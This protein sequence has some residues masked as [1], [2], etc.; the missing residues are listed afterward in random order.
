ME[1]NILNLP[2]QK[3]IIK[4]KLFP[5]PEFNKSDINNDNF[6]NKDILTESTAFNK[7]DFY[8]S[9]MIDNDSVS[10]IST[11]DDAKLITKII[12]QHCIL[13]GSDSQNMTITD[14]TAGVG[15]NVISFSKYFNFVN[16][17]ELDAYR[18]KCLINNINVYK[19]E[20]ILTYCDDSLNLIN[21]LPNQNVIFI[22]PPWGGKN[23]KKNTNIRLKLNNTYIED[24]C[25]NLFNEE[26]TKSTP[27]I[28]CFKLP[29]NYDLK[30]LYTE[31]NKNNDFKIFCYDLNKMFIIIIHK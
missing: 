25:I 7:L 8:N 11:P 24:I 26:I 12:C 17:I 29:K 3:K 18:Y 10:Y 6:T 1:N 30:T 9:L 22:D 4:T 31:I 27:E 21:K 20:N 16:A 14:T 28:I 23:Y 13:I 19:L 2:E 15:G 5:F